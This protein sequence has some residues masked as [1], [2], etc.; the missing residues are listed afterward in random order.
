MFWK[1]AKQKRILE[2][3]YVECPSC[4]TI[5]RAANWNKLAQ[6]TYGTHSPDIRKAA[7]NKG[8]SFPFQ[9]PH[10]FKGYSAHNVHFLDEE[11]HVHPAPLK[12]SQ[13]T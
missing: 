9:C 7:I 8:N 6:E 4:E 10:C 2:A 5:D 3:T 12:A 1:S 13:T 11:Q